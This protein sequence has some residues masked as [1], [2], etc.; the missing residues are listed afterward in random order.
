[1]CTVMDKIIHVGDYKRKP[2]VSNKKPT[3]YWEPADQFRANARS[4]V[5][6]ISLPPD[7]LEE[8]RESARAFDKSQRL[9]QQQQKRGGKR[10]AKQPE[11][12]RSEEDNVDNSHNNNN[13][14]KHKAH[15][16]IESI[17]SDHFVAKFNEYS[18]GNCERKE[19][20]I[21]MDTIA[22]QMNQLHKEHNTGLTTKTVPSV[23]ALVGTEPTH[24]SDGSSPKDISAS[25]VTVSIFAL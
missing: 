3:K 9:Q 11:K 24:V 14:K 20:E 2:Y 13:E 21:M 5:T 12:K 1:M 22:Q 23:E 4:P 8:L 16:I 6:N 19:L 25:S 15:P 17:I 7:I 18:A 10:K